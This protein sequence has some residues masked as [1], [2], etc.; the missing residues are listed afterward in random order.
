MYICM[1]IS[2]FLQGFGSK[3][4]SPPHPPSKKKVHEWLSP[5]HT[6]S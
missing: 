6:I 4:L 5:Q 3:P 2:C 1:L